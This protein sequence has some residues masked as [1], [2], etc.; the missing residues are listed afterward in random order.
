MLMLMFLRFLIGAMIIL[1]IIG[2]YL[3]FANKYK[4]LKEWDKFNLVFFGAISWVMTTL[5]WLLSMQIGSL[6]I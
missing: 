1:T 5:F 2:V 3:F 6:F 4:P